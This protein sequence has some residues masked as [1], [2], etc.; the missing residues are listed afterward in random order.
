MCSQPAISK[1]SLQ[2]NA[3]GGSLLSLLIAAVVTVSG[4]LWRCWLAQATFFNTDEAWHFSLANQNSVRAAY[5]ASLTISHPPLLILV[6]YY[7]RAVGTSNLMLRL[8]SVIAGAAFCWFFYRWLDMVAGRAAAWTGLILATFLQPMITTSAEVRQNPLMLLFAMCAIYFLEWA[9]E[10]SSAIAMLGSSMCLALAMLAHYS[11]FFVAGALGLYALMRIWSDKPAISVVIAWI[12]GQIAC[13]AVAAFLYRTHLSRLSSLLIQSLLPQQYLYSSYFHKGEDHLLP[14]LYRGTFGVFRFV[15]G[16]TQIG[17][18]AAILFAVGVLALLFGKWDSTTHSIPLAIFLVLPFALNWIAAAA[19]QYPYGRMRQCMFLAIF[20]LAGI[21]IGL[22][23]LLKDRPTPAI[24]LAIAI[25]VLCHGFG[26]LQDRDALPLADQRHENMDHAIAF[27]RSQTPSTTLVF[28]D[29]ATSYQLGH[30]LCDQKPY[31]IK[32]SADGSESFQCAGMQV[33][34][35][36]PADG[37]LTS[38]NFVARWQELNRD[39]APTGTQR[40]FVMQGGWAT[41]LGEALRSQIL[42]HS[43]IEIHSFGRYLEIFELPSSAASAR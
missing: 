22:S 8:P 40:V 7:W 2:T 39:R 35:T 31:A 37:A 6:L 19:G 16:Q 38:E 36:A 4:L 30:Y 3:A 15:L 27:L 34:S 1:D 11:A 41:G 14:F 23:W 42:K 10:N 12:A 13:V 24:G 28:A 43:S 29:K 26:T 5:H 33:I 17:Q 25:V 9:L 18:I 20:A 21:S 32:R